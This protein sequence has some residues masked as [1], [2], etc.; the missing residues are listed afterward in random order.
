MKE[1]VEKKKSNFRLNGRPNKKK[2]VAAIVLRRPAVARAEGGTSG[3]GPMSAF[4][5]D[6][7]GA[8]KD[9][10]YQ[11]KAHWLS[12]DIQTKR[13]GVLPGSS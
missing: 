3:F 12:L 1:K 10:P 7:T 4:A 13:P 2:Y 11:N 5:L 6:L 9:R 8:N